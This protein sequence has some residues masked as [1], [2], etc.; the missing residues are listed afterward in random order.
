MRSGTP[1][2]HAIAMRYT[3]EDDSFGDTWSVKLVIAYMIEEVSNNLAASP[4]KETDWA[5]G[6]DCP[7]AQC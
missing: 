4:G 7:M 2:G 5:S 3:R 6:S 1:E